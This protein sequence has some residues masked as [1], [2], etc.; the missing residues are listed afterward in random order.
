MS[1]SA[2]L[3]PESE[4]VALPAAPDLTPEG[5][6]E[7]PRETRTHSPH[8]LGP[9]DVLLAPLRLIQRLLFPRLLDRYVMGELLGPLAFGWGLFIVLFVLSVNLFR[10]ASM[11]ARGAPLGDVGQMLALQVVLASVYCLPMAM[12]LAGLLAFGRLSG[13]SELIATQ[14]GGVTNLRVMRNA[15]WLGLILSFAG[16]AINEYAIPPAAQRLDDI[17]DRVETRLRG[18]VLEDLLGDRAF[19]YQEMDKGQLARLVVAKKFEAAEAPRPAVLRGVTY[20]S[21]QGGRVE[22]VVEAERAEWV[23]QDLARRGGTHHWR[24]FDANSQLMMRLTPGQRVQV[25]SD[26]L[27]FWLNKGPEEVARQKKNPM[28]MNYGELKGYLERARAEGVRGK[29]VR[30]LE[31]AA[32][33]KLAIPFAALVMALIGPPLAVRRQRAATS[34]GI[35][36]SLLVIILYYV[37]MGFLG[38]LGTNRQ[39]EPVVAAWGCN[40]AGCALGVFLAWRSAR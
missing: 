22:M 24:F 26:T 4:R 6:T 37:G 16:L 36:L 7:G 19:T 11:V 8:S 20:M 23:G 28:E 30:E 18:R 10:L 12:L 35:G 33:Q 9:L 5:E 34:V 2:E 29:V 31:V 32:E 38:V 1:T 21:Y 13:E 17:K 39:L 15:V 25:H 14:T 3:H 27:D 40:L